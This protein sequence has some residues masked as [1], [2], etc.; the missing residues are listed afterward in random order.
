M[1]RLGRDAEEVRQRGEADAARALTEQAARQPD[2]VDDGR[3]DPLAR[4]PLDLALEEREVEARVVGD[5][6]GVTREREQ[7]AHRE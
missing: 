3:C 4:E 5:D 6:G 2:G 7:A 1:A